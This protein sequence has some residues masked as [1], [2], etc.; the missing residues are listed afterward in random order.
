MPET[1]GAIAYLGKNYPKLKE[2]TLAGFVVSC[3]GDSRAWGYIA[4]RTGDTLA[5]KVSRRVL[6][7]FA[8]EFV[9]DFLYFF[10]IS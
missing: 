9:F 10:I 3:I 6:T 7:R 1:I 4:S 2:F 8:K 5:D